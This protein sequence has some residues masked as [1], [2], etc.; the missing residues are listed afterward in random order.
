MTKIIVLAAGFMVA[1]SAAALAHS[2]EARLSEQA[3]MIEEGRRDGSITWREG[4]KLR[5]EQREI[6]RVKASLEADGR[7]SRADKRIL[8]RMQ[9]L[10]EGHII[11]E[12]T[13]RWR[14]LWW[15]PRV[16]R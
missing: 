15:L 4:W 10:A 1:T 11:G 3:G 16:G 2:N 7:L 14:R 12:A 5:R 9:D 13:D 8:F 6:Q